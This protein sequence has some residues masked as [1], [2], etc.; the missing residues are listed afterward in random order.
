MEL[1]KLGKEVNDNDGSEDADEAHD[2]EDSAS[3][4]DVEK[5]PSSEMEEFEWDVHSLSR[6]PENVW[7]FIIHNIFY[8]TNNAK[9]EV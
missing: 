4:P 1:H 5:P 3:D 7:I 9:M 8:K 2:A 6:F